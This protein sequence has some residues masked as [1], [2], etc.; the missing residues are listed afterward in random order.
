[1]SRSKRKLDHIDYALSTGFSTS[2]SFD[3]I[4]F[5]HNSLPSISFSEVDF[6]TTIGELTMSSPIIINAMTGGG[7][8]E[9]ENIN[10]RL[11]AAA[12]ETNTVMAVGSQMSA[13]KRPEESNTYR[14][15][16]QEIGTG[17]VFANLGSEATPDQA[18]QAVEMIEADALQIHLNVVQELVMPE[19]DRDFKG[20]LQRMEAIASTINVPVIVKEVGFGLSRETVQRLWNAGISIVDTGGK[21]G[22]NFSSIENKR[23]DEPYSFFDEWGLTAA[24]SIAEARTVSPQISIIG[25]GGVRHGA[26]IAKAIAMGADACG[27]AGK[28]LS[29]VSESGTEGAVQFIRRCQQELAVVMTALGAASVSDLKRCPLIIDN[30][31]H[32]WLSE[33]GIDTKA[34]GLRD[35][36]LDPD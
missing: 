29:A 27:M 9:T 32:H 20:A 19:G 4:R 17:L 35:S 7:G 30:Q 8:L 24:A 5:V 34:F 16:R 36:S 23:R 6:S 11:A 26:D 12:R 14:A 28:M 10:R 15:V 3:D 2:N 33:R 22:T 25:S 21:G 1:M 31:T 13:I 18:Q